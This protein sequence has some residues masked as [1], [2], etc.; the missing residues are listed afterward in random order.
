MLSIFELADL[1]SDSTDELDYVVLI[2][3]LFRRIT[4]RGGGVAHG[5]KLVPRD[6]QA[7][8]PSKPKKLI[9]SI[10]PVKSS[11]AVSG[12]KAK[13]ADRGA[14]PVAVSLVA[15]GSASRSRIVPGPKPAA[16]TWHAV[17]ARV[18]TGRKVLTPPPPPPPP[19]REAGRTLKHRP[20]VPSFAERETATVARAG[21]ALALGRHSLMGTPLESPPDLQPGRTTQP[22]PTIWKLPAHAGVVERMEKSVEKGLDSLSSTIAERLLGGAKTED[23]GK[24]AAA[25]AVVAKLA[26]KWRRSIT[27]ALP[28]AA[29]ETGKVD[30]AGGG[31]AGGGGGGAGGARIEDFRSEARRISEAFWTINQRIS[32]CLAAAVGDD[33]DDD[34]D[35]DSNT[36]N[37]NVPFRVAS[38]TQSYMRRISSA[39]GLCASAQVPARY[40]VAPAEAAAAALA[41]LAPPLQVAP[42][43][44]EQPRLLQVTDA[45]AAAA[46]ASMVSDGRCIGAGYDAA[47]DDAAADTDADASSP[48]TTRHY[49]VAARVPPDVSPLKSLRRV[50]RKAFEACTRVP[51]LGGGTGGVPSP[52]PPPTT[53]TPRPQQLMAAATATAAAASQQR[54][55]RCV[56]SSP[57]DLSSWRRLPI[58]R[59]STSGSSHAESR[60]LSSRCEDRP[61]SGPARPSQPC[62]VRCA[63][64]GRQVLPD[65]ATAESRVGTSSLLPVEGHSMQR[66]SAARAV[67]REHALA[68]WGRTANAALSAW[69]AVQAAAPRVRAC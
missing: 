61:S 2:N 30:A 35:S 23:T 52:P 56:D 1:W 4:S 53:T 42:P 66:R 11:V 43:A 14:K 49:D 3:K 37:T 51:C 40:L 12:P 31:E 29:T 44:S 50:P 39:P 45:T 46:A 62:A 36:S 48:M 5:I 10:R 26:G 15:F 18:D 64:W 16:A 41:A 63:G 21:A 22:V 54:I 28:A 24:D 19:P 58:G 60:W 13:S 20:L 34:S 32:S 47:A 27:R 7:D 67:G 38:E 69:P 9:K 8:S 68:Q 25:M 6:E 59:R 17:S 57:T 33:D 55:S 65:R